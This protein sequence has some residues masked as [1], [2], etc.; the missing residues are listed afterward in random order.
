MGCQ[1]AEPQVVGAAAPSGQPLL[2]GSWLE[3]PFSPGV[4]QVYQTYGQGERDH[5]DSHEHTSVH[6]GLDIAAPAG[7]PVYSPLSGEVAMNFDY[8]YPEWEKGLAIRGFR[9]GEEVF[10][11]MLH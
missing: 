6:V 11:K 1:K 5:P 2:G 7:T 3:W 8:A 9:E 4:G 10:I